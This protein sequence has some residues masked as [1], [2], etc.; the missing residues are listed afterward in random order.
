M[1]IV[2]ELWGVVCDRLTKLGITI[3]TFFVN[4]W[5]KF[6][7]FCVRFAKGVKRFFV[8]FGPSF[9]R[10]WVWFGKGSVSFTK[11]TIYTF[12][13][14]K[15]LTPKQREAYWDKVTTGILVLVF[16]LPVAILAYILLWFVMK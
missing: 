4:L 2:K 11:E 12:K 15:S 1:E 3:A 10:F 5:K 14:Y 8:N 7:G 13:N 6:S 16:C 9:I